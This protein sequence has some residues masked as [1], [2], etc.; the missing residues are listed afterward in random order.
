[1]S[2]FDNKKVMPRFYFLAII[3]TL[4]AVVIIGKAIYI[5]SVKSTYW[6]EVASRVKKDSVS[7]PAV[8][9]NILSCDGQIMASSLPE[10]KLFID[11]KTIHDAGSDSIWE[12]KLDSISSGLSA[13]FPNRSKEQYRRYL[14]TGRN[15]QSRRWPIY[16]GRV[17]Y[18]T[19][20]EVKSLPV[21]RLRGYTG[22]F[23][24][25]KFDSRQHPYGSLAVRTIG[26]LYPGKDEAKNGLEQFYDSLL[27]GK[28]GIIHRRKILNKYLNI[29]DT[30]PTDGADILTTIDVNMQDLAE[31]TLLNKLKDK[32][33][34]G[35]VGVAI[36]MD[37]KTGDIKAIVNMEKGAN[38]RYS[39]RK[40]HAISDLMEPGSVFKTVSL[41]TVLE[42]GM[43]DTSRIVETG[44]GI[45]D[46]HGRAMRDHNW[47]RGGYGTINLARA[48]EVSSNIGIS[49]VIEDYYGRNP[50]KFVEGI[51]RTG[52]TTDFKL[53]LKGYSPARI[54]MPKKNSRGQWTNWSKT[55]LPWMSIGYETQ[56]PPISTLAFYN[57]IANDGRMMYPRFV[58]AVV[59]NGETIMEFPPEVVPG[60]E[61]ICSKKTAKK[62][63]A[64]LEHVVSRGTGKPAG[65]KSFK[66]AGKTGTAQVA[67]GAAGYKSGMVRYLLSFVGFFPADAP[68]YSCIVCIQ[69]T[70]LPASG[71]MSAGV[72]KEIAE[73]IMAQNL[74]MAVIDAKD[75]ASIPVPDV[76]KGN[77][78]SA[79]TVLN[80]LGIKAKGNWNTAP[81]SNAP[82]WG[83]G[84]H[85]KHSV[86]L[87]K[88]HSYNHKLVPDVIGMG[89]RDAVYLMESR[90]IKVTVIGRGRVHRQS[91]AAGQSIKK[92]ARCQLILE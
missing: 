19:F 24:S 66:I 59:K 72:F 3:M 70:G 58:Q 8:R 34:N 71:S 39:E 52:I 49:R 1:M 10:Y 84:T 62:V 56:V 81:T 54:R 73:G 15:K 91:L 7:V 86:T 48:L 46:M 63:Q 25:E 11:F 31:R 42:D 80:H 57:A 13:L 89:A 16:D 76:K 75:T 43:C 50:E 88:E 29:T 26:D 61:R 27:R 5:M 79:G 68:R 17:D 47:Q 51:Y 18:N 22:G 37:V 67:Q 33:V 32:N 82:T 28:N 6:L 60:K 85:D 65:S 74:K 64:A 20:C 55:T 30:P 12:D 23:Y 69:K 83:K 90:N 35:Q 87:T 38:G 78:R 92:G 40:N 77:I 41:L 2:K 14:E 9:G 36:V 45:F 4:M 44:S 53:P 21:F